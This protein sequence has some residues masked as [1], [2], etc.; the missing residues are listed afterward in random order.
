MPVPVD[1]QI[2]MLY[3]GV[4]G[5]L[6]DVPINDVRR[7]E[8]EFLAFLRS[9]HPDLLKTLSTELPKEAEEQLKRLLTAFKEEKKFAAVSKEA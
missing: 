5:F 7:F 2:A 6:D 9:K 4:N 1:E 8:R 3:A